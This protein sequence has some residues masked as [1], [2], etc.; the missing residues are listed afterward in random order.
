M[1]SVVPQ[2]TEEQ[3]LKNPPELYFCKKMF[4][5]VPRRDAD[6]LSGAHSLTRWAEPESVHR[7]AL[8][9]M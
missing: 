7:R 1:C 9:I 2:K 8:L 4:V 5:L 3:T 6:W